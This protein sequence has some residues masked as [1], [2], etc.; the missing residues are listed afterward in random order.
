MMPM[1]P[2]LLNNSLFLRYYRRW[3]ENPSSVVFAPIS[4]YFLR[5]GM[6]D[7]ALH[8]CREG[9]KQHPTL[10]SG[11]LVMARVYLARGDHDRAMQ[12]VRTV[13][14]IV[15]D[16]ESALELK[17]H[18]EDSSGGKPSDAGSQHAKVA[19]F[20][21]RETGRI[22]SWET[23]TMA[24]IYTAQGHYDRAR[25]IYNSILSRDPG[26]EAARKGLEFLP[27]RVEE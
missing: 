27:T 25:D 5:Y 24:N 17:R 18:I 23:V 6:I 20:K 22:P 15:S 12:S 16:N 4:E 8:V 13:L 26:N 10:V 7:E 3:Q 21:R 2:E 1:H 11:H 19:P 9:T 14:S